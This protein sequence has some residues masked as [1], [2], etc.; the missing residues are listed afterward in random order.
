MSERTDKHQNRQFLM[1]ICQAILSVTVGFI[2]QRRALMRDLKAV[3]D[4]QMFKE[5]FQK[6][7][8]LHKHCTC[9]N[10]IHRGGSWPFS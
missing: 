6:H 5:L 2:A 1:L 4:V 7:K 3:E 9:M 10:K 8:G